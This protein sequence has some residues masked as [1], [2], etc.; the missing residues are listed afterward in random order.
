VREYW[1]IDPR[2]YQQQADF[3]TL[4][5]DALYHPAPPDEQGRYHSVILPNFW[6]D[7]DWLWQ[8]NLRDPQLALAEIMISIDDLPTEAKD[9][10][11]ALYSLLADRS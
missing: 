1:I 2:P 11:Q 5:E 3:F 4:G 8:E 10:Y 7:M 9:T 6:L